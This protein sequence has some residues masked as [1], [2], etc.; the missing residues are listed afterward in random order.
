MSITPA[1][2]R[3]FIETELSALEDPRVVSH[4]QSLIAEPEAVSLAW[5]YGEPGQTY[6][7]WLVLKHAKTGSGIAYCEFGFG[8]RCPWG[9]VGLSD[10][11]IGMDS[12]WFESFI[13]PYF[14]A[15]AV[16][17]PIWRVFKQEADS[18]PGIALTEESDWDSTWKEVYRRRAAE[19]TSRY[20]CFHSIA[21]RQKV[22][23]KTID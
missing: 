3:A 22:G 17:L 19:P 4:I 14:E 1:K 12:G 8:P 9:L 21:F 23:Q 2:I 13:E 5:D 20:V 10:M 15:P 16:D 6:P 18:Y 7:G 11:A